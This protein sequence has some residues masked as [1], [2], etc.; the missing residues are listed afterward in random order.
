MRFILFPI[1]CACFFYFCGNGN[2]ALS[3]RYALL[4]MLFYGMSFSYFFVLRE[5]AL[6]GH[7]AGILSQ[8]VFFIGITFWN[9]VTI[10]DKKSTTTKGLKIPPPNQDRIDD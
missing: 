1:L 9:V 5:N 10:K 2:R 4:S 8:I 7:I 6:Y 3:I